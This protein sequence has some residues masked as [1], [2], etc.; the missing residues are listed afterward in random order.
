MSGIIGC[1]TVLCFV[2]LM[3]VPQSCEITLARC[4]LLLFSNSRVRFQHLCFSVRNLF[5]DAP[6]DTGQMIYFRVHL[7]DSGH[8]IRIPSIS[9][10]ANHESIC[11]LQLQ[12]HSNFLNESLSRIPFDVVWNSINSWNDARIIYST[13]VL[14]QITGN[15]W[16]V[17]YTVFVHIRR[18]DR[19]IWN[20]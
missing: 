8:S 17:R 6:D 5:A 3:Y 2:R 10:I 13:L 15:I 9:Q 12:L 19:T 16:C 11:P 18:N 4:I 20:P 7:V 14:F 1:K